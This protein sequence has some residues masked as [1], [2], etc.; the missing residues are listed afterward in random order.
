MVLGI[1]QFKHMHEDALRNEQR[2][3]GG[4]RALGVASV[5]FLG[6]AAGISY[7]SD[8]AEPNQDEKRAKA[9][10]ECVS[11]DVRRAF[12][13]TVKQQDFSKNTDVRFTYSMTPEAQ[14][15]IEDKVR[16]PSLS[17]ATKKKVLTYS[18][19]GSAGF[20][21]LVTGAAFVAHRQAGRELKRRA[22]GSAPAAPSV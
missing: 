3:L 15:C 16:E 14:K 11:E 1:R 18:F 7:F 22:E 21:L 17:T 6:A 13:T 5:V 20:L 4:A 8:D 2:T 10:T 12:D 19:G 9:Q